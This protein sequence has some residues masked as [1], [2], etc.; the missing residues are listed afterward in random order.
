M[1]AVKA[2]V[3]AARE[4]RI[5]ASLAWLEG[6]DG[7][8]PQLEA[9]R[10]WVVAHH[11][12]Q[13]A[14]GRV[15]VALASLS[16][17]SPDPVTGALV[18]LAAEAAGIHKEAGTADQVKALAKAARAAFVAGAPVG[19][20]E[21]Q[22]RLPVFSTGRQAILGNAARLD[23]GDVGALKT[24]FLALYAQEG[25]STLDRATLIQH[26]LWLVVADAKKVATMKAPKVDGAGTVAFARRG[27]GLAA[28][29]A[30]GTTSVTVAA[31]DGVATLRAK[32]VVPA[33]SA[34]VVADGFL[35]Q[36]KYWSIGSGT[37]R[38]ITAGMKIA[39]GDLVQVQLL[40]DLN[41]ESRERSAYTIVEDFIPA[42]FSPLRED[43]EFRGA[44]LSLSLTPSQQRQRT[45][46]PRKVTF[47]LE[48]SAW[49]MGSPRELGYVMRA[50]FVGTFIA[51]PSTVEDMYKAS[52]RGRTASSSLT[53]TPSSNGQ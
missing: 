12:P 43:K 18:A 36:R 15:R 37:R 25:L 19:A 46:S 31:F 45:F 14:A 33:A 10:A 50:D 30:D 49:W 32:R 7:L 16:T 17:S 47:F 3:V 38:Q 21:D 1:P 53:I 44:P 24:R 6:Q 41:G 39:Q 48:E 40:I 52:A 11:D 9:W 22:W 4:P 35:I 8:S 34:P 29:L 42:G 2:K 23:G 51:P 5:V 26:S 13:R 20:T 27:A 28:S